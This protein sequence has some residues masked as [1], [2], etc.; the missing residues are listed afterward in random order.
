[1]A[2]YVRA[3][4][5]VLGLENNLL[6]TNLSFYRVGPGIEF[7]QSGLAAGSLPTELSR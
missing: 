2:V 7:K 5:F 4:D 6:E 3:V 1:M